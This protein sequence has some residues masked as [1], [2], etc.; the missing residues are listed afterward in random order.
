[1]RHHASCGLQVIGD[2]LTKRDQ[3]NK[4]N[5]D[6]NHAQGSSA[7]QHDRDADFPLNGKIFEAV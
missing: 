4:E 5:G 6:S 2:T 7:G 3:L 1:L